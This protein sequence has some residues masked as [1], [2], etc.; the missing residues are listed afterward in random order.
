MTIGRP[1]PFWAECVLP[2]CLLLLAGLLAVADSKFF[3]LSVVDQRDSQPVHIAISAPLKVR[4]RLRFHG[5]LTTGIVCFFVDGPISASSCVENNDGRTPFP[6]LM[7]RDFTLPSAGDYVFWV[8]VGD[9][10]SN[11]WR[12][13]I[14]EN[15]H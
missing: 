6:A 4:A 3:E 13:Q 7:T 9:E 5:Q 1:T 2:V 15:E 12:L 10:M 14:Q 8:R 11:R